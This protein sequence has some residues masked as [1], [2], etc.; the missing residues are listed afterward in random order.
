MSSESLQNLWTNQQLSK[1]PLTT[2]IEN[3]LHENSAMERKECLTNRVSGAMFIV[4]IPLLLWFAAIGKTA[5]VREGYALMAVG[6][7][8]S[9]ACHWMYSSWKRQSLPG[10]V[11][12]K[13]L[14]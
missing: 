8:V 5:I 1:E 3:V 11:D 2:M 14:L 6:L 13:S 7:A 12:T 4:L 9:L 10:P